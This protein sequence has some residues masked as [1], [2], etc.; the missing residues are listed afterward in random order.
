ME[1]AGQ[2]GARCGGGGGETVKRTSNKIKDLTT[3]ESL[4]MMLV[5]IF[6]LVFNKICSRNSLAPGDGVWQ[7]SN[8]QSTA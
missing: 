2:A 1:S 4:I 5:Q 8:T 7:F 6:E 3:S